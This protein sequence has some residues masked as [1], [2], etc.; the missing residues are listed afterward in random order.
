MNDINN[1]FLIQWCGPFFSVEDLKDWELKNQSCKKRN[2]YILTGKEYN[3]RKTSY[4]CGMSEQN[5][6]YKRFENHKKYNKIQHDLNIW[7]GCFSCQEQATHENISIVETMIISYWQPELNEKKKKYYP[8]Q[9]ICLINRWHN[10][11][12]S[13]R[14]RRKYP[15]QYLD[16]VLIYDNDSGKIWGA[17]YLK[18]LTK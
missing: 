7:I 4:Y 13:L 16:D 9:C 3:R 18:D 14:S 12:Q 15:A 10:I 17:E 5:P 1:V 11:N 8:N 6:L 2:L